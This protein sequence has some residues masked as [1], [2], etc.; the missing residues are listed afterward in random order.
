MSETDTPSA[1]AIPSAKPDDKQADSAE[2]RRQSVRLT[3]VYSGR[4]CQFGKAY[5]CV[6]SDVSAGGAKVRLKDPKDFERI[7]RSG[8]I[9]LIFERLS[10]YKALNTVVAWVKPA[11]YVVG[12]RFT[13]PELR[14]RVVM[15]RL[16]PT[17]WSLAHAATEEEKDQ[18][19][20]APAPQAQPGEG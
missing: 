1:A 4:I 13:D 5:A 9:Q 16:M 17:R 8:E 18:D 6:I 20:S 12:L 3:T 7:T 11:E 2:S 15:R 19:A 14:R 10:D